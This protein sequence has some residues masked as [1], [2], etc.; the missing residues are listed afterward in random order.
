MKTS[1]TFVA[2]LLC[3]FALTP[4]VALA[5]PARGQFPVVIRGQSGQNTLKVNTATTPQRTEIGCEV[6]QEAGT[7]VNGIRF[8]GNA[9]GQTPTIIALSCPNGGDA[10][11]GIQLT[12]AG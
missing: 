1:R 3:A 12:G 8:T 2:A 9:T 10:N 6:D 5:Q 7:T 11:P 4:G